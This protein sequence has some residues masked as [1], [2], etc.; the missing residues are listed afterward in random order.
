MKNFNEKKYFFTFHF[1]SFLKKNIFT[2]NSKNLFLWFYKHFTLF[3]T[4]FLTL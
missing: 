4:L 2:S 1:S 3:F